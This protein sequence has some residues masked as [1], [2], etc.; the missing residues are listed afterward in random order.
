MRVLILIKKS[1]KTL[2]SYGVKRL[3]FVII[4]YIKI[5]SDYRLSAYDDSDVKEPESPVT[6]YDI[7]FINGCDYSL[8]HPIRYRVDHQL[9]QLSANNLSCRIIYHQELT[10]DDVRLARGFIIFRCP[11]SEL[12]EAFVKKAKVLNKHVFFDIDDLVVD[13]KY[14]DMIKFVREMEPGDKRGYDDGVWKMRKTLELCDSLITTTEHL[15]D[16]L[17][18]INPDAFINR[19]VASEE[20]VALSQQAYLDEVNARSL[21]IG[22]NDKVILGYFSGSITHNEDYEMILPALLRI[23]AENDN[24]MLMIVGILDVP[25]ELKGFGERIIIHPFLDWKILP[26]LIASIDINLVPL[27]DTLFNACKSENKWVE[28]SLVKVLTIASTIGAFSQMIENGK[29]G[30]LCSNE[31]EW[32]TA[33]SKM[34]HSPELRKIIANEAY[35]LCIKNTVTMYTGMSLSTHVLEKLKPS[36]FMV[37]PGLAISGGVYVALKH[38]AFLQKHGFDVTVMSML[39]SD[40]WYEFEGH[41]FPILRDSHQ[42]TSK[43]DKGIATMWTTLAFLENYTQIRQRYYLVQNFETDFYETNCIERLPCNRTY[44]LFVPIQMITISIWCQAWLRENFGRDSR[45]APNGINTE[46]FYPVKRSFDG[47]IRVLVEGDCESHYKNVDESFEITNMLDPDKFEI[48]YMSYNAKPKE[49]Y[50]VDKFLHK[51]PSNEVDKIYRSC[52]ILL[53]T[54]I[55]ESFSYP[56]LEMMATGGFA[57][58]VPN[59]GNAEYLVDNHNCLLY[60]Q[61]DI[62]DALCKI[63]KICT[64]DNLREQLY[65]GG[66]KTANSRCWKSIEGDILSLY[67]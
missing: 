12:I 38:S 26:R 25:E 30:V 33:L 62:E 54:S 31:D 14:T 29:T 28:A 27:A 4:N 8:P 10:L 17:R 6:H 47:K 56:P 44:N 1:I 13:T 63:Y 51:I 16:E 61:G 21:Q 58:V 34:I 55:L 52:D 42:I 32:Y 19:N 50:R 35:N 59:G 3:L 11:H 46:Q 5:W 40:E 48:W 64:D 18:H 22:R 15:A 7:I 53:K 20:M 9:E 66:Q 39:D 36:A 57:V 43:I 60:N 41:V 65:I 49:N 2:R 23:L 67:E 24:V 37:I 45:Y